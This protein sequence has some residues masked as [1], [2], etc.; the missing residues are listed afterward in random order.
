VDFEEHPCIKYTSKELYLLTL[1]QFFFGIWFTLSFIWV[2]G[3]AA[4]TYDGIKDIIFVADELG[5]L[6]Y[7][8]PVAMIILPPLILGVILK[9]IAWIVEGLNLYR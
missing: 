9:V 4:A 7:L 5:P 6:Y 2:C 8:F 3:V 1:K